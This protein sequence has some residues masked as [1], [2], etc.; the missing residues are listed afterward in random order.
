M[1]TLE[2]AGVPAG[3]VASITEMLDHPQTLARDMVLEVEHSELGPVKTLGNPV[4]F[5]GSERD[6]AAVTPRGAPLLGEH[7]REVLTD[8]GFTTEE[9]DALTDSGVAMEAGK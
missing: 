5:S 2:A 8:Y 9:V 6:A 1:S 4:K 7:T 3:P